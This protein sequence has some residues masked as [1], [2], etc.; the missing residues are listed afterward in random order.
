MIIEIKGTIELMCL[1]HPE[2]IL[3]PCLEKLSAM[4]LVLGVNDVETT[5]T[6]NGPLRS[7]RLSLITR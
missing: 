4:K 3:L 2:N 7:D 6:M 1:N 5:V